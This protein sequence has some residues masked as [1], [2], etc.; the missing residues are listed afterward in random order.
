MEILDTHDG[1]P[2]IKTLS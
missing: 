1:L 2:Q